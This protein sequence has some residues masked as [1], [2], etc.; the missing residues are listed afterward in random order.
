M[1]H[2]VQP[3]TK[4]EITQF[5]SSHGFEDVGFTTAAPFDDHRAFL[6][7]RNAEYGWA[8][9]KGLALLE[10]TDPRTILPD[11]KA[12]IILMEVYVRHTYPREMEAHFGRC[13][14]DDDRITKHGLAKRIRAFRGELIAR[15]IKTKCPF[16]LPHRAAA[17]RAGMGTFGKNCLFYSHKIARKSSWILPIAIVIDQELE[18][19]APTTGMGCPDF[20][21]NTCIAACPTRALKGNG[22]IDPRRCISY[23]SYFG[24]DLTPEEL[25]EPMGIMVYGCDRCQN[26]CPR[27]EAWLAKDRP[28]NP[29]VAAKA[30]DF[31][32]TRLLH[33]DKPYFETKIWPHMFYMDSTEIWR[34]KMN[35]ARAM[36]NTRD[37]DFVPELIR[38]LHP[39][40]D[41]RV[42]A[43]IAWSLGK[44]GGQNARNTLANFKK[45]ASGTVLEEITKALR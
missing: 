25:R 12:I 37:R 20:C 35:V 4:Q 33:M 3:I 19:D 26:V 13:Y 6:K 31:S 27:N 36:G 11:A 22:T 38:A 16:N 5:A 14:L 28:L 39:G 30:K 44:L 2:Q 24:E 42:S 40:Q 8:R 43:M 29:R 10:G 9:E 17:A 18:P 41:E 32:L 23:L 7:N 34:W 21:K 1:N 45:D 15:G